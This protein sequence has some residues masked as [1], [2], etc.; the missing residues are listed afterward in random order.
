MPLIPLP[1]RFWLWKLST[2]IRLIYPNFVIVITVLETGIK[3]S[4]EISY[5]SNPI[6]VLLS[7][8][9]LSEITM[10][11]LRITPNNFLRSAR[12]AFNSA[13]NVINWLYSAS[14]L[15]RSKPV[16]AR[17]RISTIAWA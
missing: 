7:S 2:L 5:S 11:S 3:S 8:P 4:I 6:D 14:S 9:Y 12:I 17:R 15:L 13:I 10:I 16:N 1:P